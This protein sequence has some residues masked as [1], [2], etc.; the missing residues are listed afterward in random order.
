MLSQIIY[1]LTLKL[2]LLPLLGPDFGTK[3]TLLDFEPDFFL[4]LLLGFLVALPL[5]LFFLVLLFDFLREREAF[6]G[7]KA[8]AISS[9]IKRSR[10][11]LFLQMVLR[12]FRLILCFGNR[13]LTVILNKSKSFHTVLTFVFLFFLVIPLTR[14]YST[15][16]F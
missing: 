4:F 1:P 5:L 12:S 3:L 6:R 8:R 14:D 11:C 13:R 15:Q 2:T 7:T 9:R 16:S 10:N